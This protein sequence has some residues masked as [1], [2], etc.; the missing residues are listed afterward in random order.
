M[1]GPAPSSFFWDDELYSYF[2][3]SEIFIKKFGTLSYTLKVNCFFWLRLRR[4]VV[5]DIRFPKSLFN[6]Q[7]YVPRI[8][9]AALLR[10]KPI[11]FAFIPSGHLGLLT[12][13]VEPA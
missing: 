3:N 11:K 12:L 2:A 10:C 1:L 4:T 13:L 5:V 7:Y 6:I 9:T 8:P